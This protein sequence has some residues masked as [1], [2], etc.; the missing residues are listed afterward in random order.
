MNYWLIKSEPDT[1][2]IDD[3]ATLKTAGWEGVRNYQARNF[4]RAMRAGERAFFYHSRTSAPAI[5]GEV[6]VVREAHPDPTQFDPQN[7]YYDAKATPAAPRWD[8]VEVAFASKFERPLGLEEIRRAPELQRMVLVRNSR[9]S[10]QPV[11]VE[12]WRAVRRRAGVEP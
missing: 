4:L 10:V 9:L 11:T 8:Q 5:V 7:A 1:F 2:S 3:L 6:A 12:E